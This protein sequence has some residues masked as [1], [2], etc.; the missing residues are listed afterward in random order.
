MTMCFSDLI[1]LLTLD[2]RRFQR[3]RK[4][5]LDQ[6]R[7]YYKKTKF[8]RIKDCTNME[9]FYLIV[10]KML[11]KFKEKENTLRKISSQQ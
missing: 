7:S 5:S 2:V 11:N 8:L 3:F 1:N 4:K 9:R 6:N 10:F